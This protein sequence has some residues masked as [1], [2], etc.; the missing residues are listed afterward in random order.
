VKFAFAGTPRF[1][2]LVLHDLVELGHRPAVVLSQPDRPRGRGRKDAPPD[3]ASQAALLGLECLKTD[4]INSLVVL[5]RLRAV[6][7]STL[8]VAAFG[9]L[10]RRPLLEALTCFNIHASLLPEY[11][12]AAPIERALAAGE[13]TT[14]VSIMRI[15]EGLDEGPWAQ[16]VPVVIGLRDDAGS[17]ARVMALVGAV[18]LTQVFDAVEDGTVEWRE[19]AGTP[20]YAHKLGSQDCVLDTS[21]GAK[22]VHDRVRSLSPNVGARAVAGEVELKLWKT[23]PYGEPGLPAV[24]EVARAASGSPGRVLA[25]EGR[26]FVGCGVG[27]VEV[28]ELQ[29]A[30]KARMT[31]PAFLR[32][33]GERL[34]GPLTAVPCSAG[35]EQA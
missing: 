10:L 19:Q 34:G 32:G 30:S 21:L 13:A 1:A 5:E 31:A 33:Y 24:P 14:G 35:P 23:W 15:T 4:D 6:G 9:Q 3:I 17:L 25:A 18:A 22:S 27:V 7:T 11:R 2:C 12:G 20:S 8:V 26:L 29:P 28:L 16:Q